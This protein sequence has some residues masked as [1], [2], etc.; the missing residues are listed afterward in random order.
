MN[1]R[2]VSGEE[3]LVSHCVWGRYMWD[4]LRDVRVVDSL[5]QEEHYNELIFEYGFNEPEAPPSF[6]RC[7]FLHETEVSPSFIFCPAAEG[8]ATF[9][10]ELG[11]AVHTAHYPESESWTVYQCEAFALLANVN[12]GRWRTLEP[13][14][15]A[16]F[17]E[18]IRICR[19]VPLYDRALHW[20]FSLRN[21]PLQ[22]QM[23]AIARG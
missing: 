11:H 21:L 18:H 4:A 23:D 22:E 12:A 20:A 14:E 8:I 19:K 10:H 5:F 6:G 9:V 15:R 7:L 1:F 17:S 3:M 2:T 13:K 16:S